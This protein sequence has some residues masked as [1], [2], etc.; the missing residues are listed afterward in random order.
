[1]IFEGVDHLKGEECDGLTSFEYQG[2]LV[3]NLTKN[4]GDFG[5]NTDWSIVISS[6]MLQK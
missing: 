6:I 2:Q 3:E 4:S 1:M 5:L